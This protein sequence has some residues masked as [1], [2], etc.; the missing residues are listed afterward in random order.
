MC[1]VWL[2]RDRQ[3][4]NNPL[5]GDGRYRFIAESQLCALV[6]LKFQVY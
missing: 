4:S 6:S 2:R 3:N 5:E 1:A